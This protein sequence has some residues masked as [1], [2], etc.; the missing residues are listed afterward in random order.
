MKAYYGEHDAHDAR[1]RHAR[2]QCVACLSCPFLLLP[3]AAHAC[4]QALPAPA[5][6]QVARVRQRWALHGGMRGALRTASCARPRV[7]MPL[8]SG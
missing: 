5:D 3:R 4:S 6:V 7:R 8:T 2:P 1:C